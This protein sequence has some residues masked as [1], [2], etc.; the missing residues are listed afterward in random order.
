M[1]FSPK[2][3][4]ASIKKTLRPAH[5]RNMV[6]ELIDRYRVSEKRA[7][8][9]IQICRNSYRYRSTRDEQVSLA[10]ADQ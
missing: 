7:C 8:R 1:T 9:V 5:K 4:Q 2:T 10:H 6:M 3:R